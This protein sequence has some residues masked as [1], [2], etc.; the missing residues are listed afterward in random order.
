MI[1]LVKPGGRVRGY[2]I[3]VFRGAGHHPPSYTTP[4]MWCEQVP[5]SEWQR[6]L[7]DPSTQHAWIIQ[8]GRKM[9]EFEFR[10]S[11]SPLAPTRGVPRHLTSRPLR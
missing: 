4:L 10:R 1:S 11:D 6:I 3:H 9:R 2:R 7:A 8:S 5:L